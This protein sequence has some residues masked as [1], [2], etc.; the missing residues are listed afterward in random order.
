MAFLF[1]P[2]WDAMVYS[3]VMNQLAGL[4]FPE[5]TVI[6]R[7]GEIGTS[8]LGAIAVVFFLHWYIKRDF[9]RRLDELMAPRI[10]CSF[11]G[12]D[13][14][15]IRRHVSLTVDRHVGYTLRRERHDVDYYRIRV[16]S[17]I[18]AIHNVSGHLTSIRRGTEVIF[19]GENLLLTFAIGNSSDSI[20]RT[21]RSGLPEY[22]DLAMVTDSNEVILATHNFS[23]PSSIAYDRL[24]A[25]RGTYTFHVV[26]SSPEAT[27]TEIDVT[28]EWS[29]DRAQVK[30][31]NVG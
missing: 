27:A 24:F 23:G 28:M 25:E 7:F 18:N 6:E 21:V 16:E 1:R 13:P 17:G 8:V 10:K 9:Q 5:A 29:A 11:N 4:G 3:W 31:H 14:G 12:H 2:V 26:V 22:L 15:C 19:D 20:S 30:F